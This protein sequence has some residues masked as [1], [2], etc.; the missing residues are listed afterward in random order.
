M[1]RF[2]RSREHEMII[3]TKATFYFRG[4]SSIG[5]YIGIASTEKRSS[6]RAR[7]AWLHAYSSQVSD[8]I[9]VVF[10]AKR[11]IV[12]FPSAVLSKHLD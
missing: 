9:A 8:E 12:I 7:V 3:T 11:K 10:K 4:S 5:M 1:D 2:A 6:A